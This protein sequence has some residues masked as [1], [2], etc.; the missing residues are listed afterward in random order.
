M[1]YQILIKPA[2]HLLIF[3]LLFGYVSLSAQNSKTSLMVYKSGAVI[4]E[5]DIAEIDSVKFYKSNSS[6]P[7][8]VVEEMFVCQHGTI[9]FKK[10]IAEIDSI[11]YIKTSNA[12]TLDLTGT[13][14]PT[15]VQGCFAFDAPAA[16]TSAAQLESLPGNVKISNGCTDM[17]NLKLS[18]SDA[19]TGTCP[20]TI[21]RTYTVKNECQSSRSVIHQ[22][23]IEDIS[24]PTISGT[25][26]TVT[27]QGSSVTAAP[28]PV[29][30][31]AA[32]EAL[33]G[34]VQ[35][36]DDC[37]AK[38][39]LTIA[40]S[41]NVSGTCP[42]I[43]D[44][45]Y[46]IKDAC[47]NSSSINQQIIIEPQAPITTMELIYIKGGTF[48]MGSPET[49]IRL[50]DGNT[51]NDET[52]HQVTL[53]SY[54]MG[55]YEV[56]NAEYAAFLNKLG[57]GADAIY[58]QGQFP[59]KELISYN[60]GTR[61]EPWGLYYSGGRWI[62]YSGYENFPVPFVTWYGAVEYAK[63]IGGRLPSEAEWEY[64]C[65]AGTTT[66]FNTGTCLTSSQANYDWR[67][68]YDGCPNNKP[69]VSWHL[70]AVNSYQP[71]GWG[72]YN[73]HG[74][75]SEWVGDWYG[76]YPTSPQTDPTGSA[77]GMERVVRGGTNSNVP[78]ACRSAYRYP[79]VPTYASSTIGFR[80]A[81]PCNSSN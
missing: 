19:I 21:N 17:P 75:I 49:E 43:I 47:Q 79:R 60:Q 29:N 58:H 52:Q 78:H 9:Y 65:R 27:I 77:N 64:A 42:I 1:N 51:K 32:L 2:N 50:P 61:F 76:Q 59:D 26:T 54:Y 7:S 33:Q 69:F 37:T 15:V 68:T 11:T 55:K 18:H 4:F 80:V 28:S 45:T 48:T 71:N 3:L 56:S 62:P 5:R 41:D 25:L 53:T 35:V 14:T 57:I 46:T 10:D 72:L 31:V 74:N 36:N 73:M 34:S 38:A 70:E 24:K 22:I 81:F 8:V 40:S 16:A 30:S 12:L 23:T 13:L 20:I 44:R 63:Y 39:N 6:N 66:P 67:Y